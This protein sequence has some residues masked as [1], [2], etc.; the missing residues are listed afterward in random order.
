MP[1]VLAGAQAAAR[2]LDG[3]SQPARRGAAALRFGSARDSPVVAPAVAPVVPSPVS[4]AVPAALSS[5]ALPPRRRREPL[6]LLR[7][8]GDETLPPPS[9][10]T[11]PTRA[12]VRAKPH[13]CCVAAH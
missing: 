3:S 5:P 6:A 4:S 8:V 1:S 13:P 12:L 2:G 9:A 11:R 7:T 10:L